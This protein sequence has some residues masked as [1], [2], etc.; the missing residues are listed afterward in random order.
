[1]AA[2][3]I[4]GYRFTNS[5]MIECIGMKS[6]TVYIYLNWNHRDGNG[7][8]DLDLEGLQISV[9]S[10]TDTSYLVNIQEIIAV[11]DFQVSS[12][13]ERLIKHNA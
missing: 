12:R 10:V 11:A 8:V 13:I 3:P 1:M 6:S 2:H 7:A 9:S 5:L 4:Y